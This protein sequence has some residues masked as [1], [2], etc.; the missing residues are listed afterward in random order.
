MSLAACYVVIIDR[1]DNTRSGSNLTL[2]KGLFHPNDQRAPV[3]LL[4]Y[5]TDKFWALVLY[6]ALALVIYML[7]HANYSPCQDRR[8]PVGLIGG[9]LRSRGSPKVLLLPYRNAIMMVQHIE[10]AKTSGLQSMKLYDERTGN[11]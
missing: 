6:L 11:A 3:P 1:V 9:G 8:H 2:P 5:L 4:Y 7:S 10:T